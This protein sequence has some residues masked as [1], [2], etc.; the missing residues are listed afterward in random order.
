MQIVM[1]LSLGAGLTYTLGRMTGS[2]RH[3]WAVWAAMAMLC[4]A[5]VTVDLRDGSSRQ[6]A[7]AWH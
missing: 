5:G 7:A 6:S 1:M 2:Q 4:L 3:G